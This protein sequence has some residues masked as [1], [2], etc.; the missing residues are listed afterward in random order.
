MLQLSGEFS[1]CQRKS[2]YYSNQII[3]RGHLE[4]GHANSQKTCGK[5]KIFF[6]WFL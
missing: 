4:D 5:S 1:G 3:A 2:F 6:G